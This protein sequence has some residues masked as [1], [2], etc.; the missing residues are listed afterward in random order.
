M[1]PTCVAFD[2]D[3]T[4]Y[5]ERDYVR[6]GFHAVEDWARK[7]LGLE[8]F[9]SRAWGLFQQGERGNIFDLLLLQSGIKPDENVIGIMV[10]LY[11]SHKPAIK[12][13]ADA[14]E[15]LR[16]LRGRVRLALISDGVPLSQ[17]NKIDALGLAQFFE[18]IVLTSELGDGFTKPHH[19]AFLQVQ[20]VLGAGAER[21]VYVADNPLKDFLGPRG[22]G[23]RTIR[24]RREG[25]LYSSLEGEGSRAADLE[26]T[27]LS[28]LA[29]SILGGQ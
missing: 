24:I 3:D 20:R 12:L 14:A 19:R 18:T 22:L 2:L 25:G 7:N 1:K 27:N 26:M 4:L 13:P 23:W 9:S 16:D 21:Y 15:C 28:T 5:L 6:S 11:R 17:R 10:D 29:S 8:D